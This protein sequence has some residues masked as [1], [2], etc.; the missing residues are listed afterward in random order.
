MDLKRVMNLMTRPEPSWVD[1]RNMKGK[2]EWIIHYFIIIPVVLYFTNKFKLLW[3]PV[4]FY[5]V[6]YCDK[7][8][9]FPIVNDRIDKYISTGQS[10]RLDI[11]LPINNNQH[12]SDLYPICN[13]YWLPSVSYITVKVWI[14]KYTSTGNHAGW[15][16]FI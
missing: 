4:G 15:T 13:Q 2:K 16:V 6:Y 11:I 3:L 9:W 14:D 1:S 8:K 12:I 10:C 5:L 7:N